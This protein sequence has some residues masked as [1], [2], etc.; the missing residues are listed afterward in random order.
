MQANFLINDNT[1]VNLAGFNIDLHNN[2]LF[3]RAIRIE[4]NFEI[5][6]EKSNGNWVPDHEFSKL[7]FIHRNVNFY[8]NEPGDNTQ[9]PED[10]NILS[11]ITFFPQSMRNI[12]SGFME[13]S[14][15]NL[16]DDIIYHFENGK[17]FRVNCDEI[18]LVVN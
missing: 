5:H 6:F 11:F 17:L 9:F 8:H 3:K 2:F 7:T 15:P 18:E 16:N 13:R 10:E 1:A 14:G 4:D 12:N